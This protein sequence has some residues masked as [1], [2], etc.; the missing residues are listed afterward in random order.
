MP[1][2][3]DRLRAA[4]LAALSAA[5]ARSCVVY[6]WTAAASGGAPLS[7]GRLTFTCPS[8]GYLAFADLEPAANWSHACCYLCID[9]ATGNARRVDAQFPPFRAP[10]GDSPEARWTVLYQAPGVAD[11]LLATAERE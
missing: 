10:R 7:F 6:L 8:D 1:L 3:I 11:A 9:G 2:P 4:A 5:E